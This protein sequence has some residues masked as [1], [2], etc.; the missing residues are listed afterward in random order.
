M[1][2]GASLWL[3]TGVEGNWFLFDGELEANCATAAALGYDGIELM[4]PAAGAVDRGRLEKALTDNGLKLST[5]S[6]GGGVMSHGLSFSSPD[7]GIR[8]RARR[9]GVDIVEFAGSFGAEAIFGMLKGKVEPG[10]ARADAVACVREAIEEAAVAAAE[11]GLNVLVEPQNRYE[12]NLINRL[13][14]A[15]ELIDTLDATNVKILADTFHMNIEERSI[16]GALRAA[17]AHIGH[18]H[19]AD[20]NR[21][22]PGH[23]HIDFGAVG[24]ALREIGYTGYT[25]V[26]CMAYPN[27]KDAA[28]A[29]MACL[30]ECMLG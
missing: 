19:L 2:A 11:Y 7:A 14:E 16:A 8:A 28:A 30:R 17:G 25:V 20:S 10:V 4:V 21:L 12:T 9:F 15:V 13:D 6:S 29:A 23:G 27:A 26:E 5:V 1:K 22:P 18:I 3:M 24:A